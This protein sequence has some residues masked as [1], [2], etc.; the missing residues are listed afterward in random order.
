[1]TLF[2]KPTGNLIRGHVLDSAVG[3][4]VERLKDLDPRLYIRWNPKKLRG[5]GLYEV[6][7]RP[8]FKTMKDYVVYGGNTYVVVDY[9]ENNF[10]NHI[11]DTPYLNYDILTRLKKMDM[12]AN[13]DRGRNFLDQT[14]SKAASLAEATKEKALTERKYELKQ[15]SSMIRDLMDYTLSGG[16]PSLIANHWK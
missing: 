7:Y 5:W 12:W 6:R 1:M 13:S 11:L 4:L 3:P 2:M 15:Q 14:E 10:A 16:D 8:E 9:V